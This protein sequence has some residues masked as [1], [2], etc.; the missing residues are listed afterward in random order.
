MATLGNNL[1]TKPCSLAPNKQP[2]SAL[3]KGQQHSQASRATIHKHTARAHRVHPKWV[4]TCTP[5]SNVAPYWLTVMLIQLC[6]S[7]DI[8]AETARHRCLSTQPLPMTETS[9]KHQRNQLH[10]YASAPDSATGR[11][12]PLTAMPQTHTGNSQRNLQKLKRGFARASTPLLLLKLNQHRS[13]CKP[14]N[15]RGCTG[16]TTEG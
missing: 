9:C 1:N 13:Q 3:T 14:P 5:A 8:S 2:E 16:N 11:S 7:G 10:P 12:K 6:R 4:H 15:K